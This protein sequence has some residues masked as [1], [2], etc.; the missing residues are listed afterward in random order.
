[1]LSRLHILALLAAFG[2]PPPLPRV[3]VSRAGHNGYASYRI[4]ALVVSTKG[5]RL[6]FLL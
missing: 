3:N 5:T 4:P 2:Y 1:M 6:A